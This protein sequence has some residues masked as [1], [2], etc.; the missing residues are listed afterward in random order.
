VLLRCSCISSPVKPV[1]GEEEDEKIGQIRD[2]LGREEDEKIR[3]VRDQLGK[4]RKVT[5]EHA[6][7]RSY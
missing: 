2:Q 7:D 4:P 1:E 6:D 5:Q 3:Q